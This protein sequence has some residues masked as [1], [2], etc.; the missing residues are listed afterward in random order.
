[1]LDNNKIIDSIINLYK[2]F[3]IRL[4]N[5]SLGLVDIFG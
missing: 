1:M 3:G 4:I 5:M 2:N